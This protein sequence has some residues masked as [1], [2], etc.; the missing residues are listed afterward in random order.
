MS[1]KG[2]EWHLRKFLAPLLFEGEV[3]PANQTCNSLWYVLKKK[4]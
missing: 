2:L 4:F 1:V 3:A